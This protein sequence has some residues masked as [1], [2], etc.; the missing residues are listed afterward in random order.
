MRSFVA[1]SAKVFQK[2]VMLYPSFLLMMIPILLIGFAAILKFP[3]VTPADSILPYLLM[4][5]DLPA[6]VIGLFC[7]GA[8]AASMSSGDAILHTA[9]SVAIR[10]GIAQIVK[11]PLSDAKERS[12]IRV[13]V[14]II[15]FVA[16]YFAVVSKTSIVG[17]LVGAYGGVAQ[18]FPIIFAAF[19][20]KKAS[21]IAAICALTGGI[22]TNT[23]FLI[24]PELKP[25]ALHEGVYGLFVNILLLV[26]LSLW[27][28]NKH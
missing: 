19:Y 23:F 5:L 21:R 15:G 9:A 1:K 16:Y 27:F 18:I 12:F 24:L 20:W 22:V 7:A 10:D 26:S 11:T 6:V 28:P 4:Q 2:S 17:L 14:L 13:A 3:G 8:L 25:F